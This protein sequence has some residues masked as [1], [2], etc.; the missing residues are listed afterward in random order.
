MK[1]FGGYL[2]S[3]LGTIIL[4]VCL[5]GVFAAADLLFEVETIVLC[6]RLFWERC[7]FLLWVRWIT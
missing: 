6:T 4:C 3:R 7:C 1:H 2:R 5:F